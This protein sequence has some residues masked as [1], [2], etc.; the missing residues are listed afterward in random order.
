MMAADLQEPTLDEKHDEGGSVRSSKLLHTSRRQAKRPQ[1]AT[2][3]QVNS[4]PYRDSR[5]DSTPNACG[6]RRLPG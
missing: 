2:A 1:G 4:T 6:E 5:K 3:R